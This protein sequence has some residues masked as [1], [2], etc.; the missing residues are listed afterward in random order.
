[1]GNISASGDAQ[2]RECP[3]GLSV[4]VAGSRSILDLTG[5]AD[6]N[7]SLRMRSTHRRSPSV[8]LFRVRHGALTRSARDGLPTTVSQSS[9][10]PLIGIRTIRVRLRKIERRGWDSTT[11]SSQ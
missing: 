2:I 4:I 5:E 8:R 7:V 1:M 10:S 11:I 9:G 6:R 3:D